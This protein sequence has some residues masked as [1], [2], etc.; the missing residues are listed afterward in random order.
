MKYDYSSLTPKEAVALQKTL[1]GKVIKQRGF[2]EIRVIAGIDVSV[3]NDIARA[4][5]VLLEFGSFKIIGQ[6]LAERAVD[7]PYIPGLLAFREVPVI[8]RAFEKLSITPDLMMVD[9]Q[10]YAHPRRFG[11][12]CHLGVELDIPSIGCAKSKL[13]G[14]FAEPAKE[15]GSVA[16]L[17]SNG[18]IIGK[19]VRTKNWIKPIFVSIGYKVDI[20]SAVSIT[21]ACAC[22]YKLPEPCRMAHI[23]AGKNG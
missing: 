13:V 1:A 4:A 15:K 11:L 16:D 14:E 20:E 9:G 23:I 7:F 10:G 17:V 5:V 6:A 18:E 21:L 19:V 22:G 12:A 3:R 2:G 8:L